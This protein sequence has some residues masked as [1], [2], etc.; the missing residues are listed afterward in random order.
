MEKIFRVVVLI[1]IIQCAIGC[2]TTIKYDL[3]DI[4]QLT[5]S[6]LNS[7]KVAV[8]PLLDERSELEK[9]PKTKFLGD[10]ETR[11]STFKDKDVP[12]GISQAMV[13]H[14][15]HVKLFDEAVLVDN[16]YS[17]LDPRTTSEL[18]TKGYDLI[19]TGEVKHFYGKSYINTTDKF[20]IVGA[21]LFPPSII[22]T[23]PIIL[24]E[25]NT[26]EGMVELV[27]L[28]LTDI[29]TGNIIW[30]G[31]FSKNLEKEYGDAAITKVPIEALKE[32]T[33]DIVEELKSMDYETQISL[34]VN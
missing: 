1:G 34:P 11:D 15:N 2:S 8:A 12:G 32:I 33:C 20:A 28:Q 14:L 31:S 3:V 16:E 21:F 18:K 25:K 19:L 9:S 17:L 7:L 29:K 27:D 26:F 23:I 13:V 22:L 24:I 30:T 10:M 5:N 4:P 6:N